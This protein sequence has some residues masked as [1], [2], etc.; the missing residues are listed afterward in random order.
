MATLSDALAKGRGTERPFNCEVHG[1][2]NASA[3]VNVIKGVWYCHACHASGSVDGMPPPTAAALAE[4]VNPAA[5]RDVRMSR[6][7]HIVVQDDDGYWADRLGFEV[8]AHYGFGTDPITGVPVYLAYDSGANLCGL[9]RRNVEGVQ[10]KY[11]YPAGWS[12]SRN[13]FG[14]GM[15]PLK[16][17]DPDVLVLVEAAADVAVL[18]GWGYLALGCYGSGLHAPQMELVERARGRRTVLVGF[19]T[20]PA[21]EHGAQQAIRRLEEA[22]VPCTRVTW[23]G[24]DPGESGRDATVAAIA[25]V[26]P[27]M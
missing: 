13:L 17:P 6:L 23:P 7:W 1:D 27:W 4:M 12:A 2:T 19:D 26:R 18:G 5:K 14:L 24:K 25:S 20:D 10:P 16:E 22:G 8:A 3:S 21:G 11:V 15:D 9:I